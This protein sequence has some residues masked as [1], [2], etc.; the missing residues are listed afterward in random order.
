LEPEPIEEEKTGAGATGKKS[1]AG[2]P[3]K[4]CGSPLLSPVLKYCF[5][6]PKTQPSR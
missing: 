6:S 3:N 2:A 4:L 5:I 1:G